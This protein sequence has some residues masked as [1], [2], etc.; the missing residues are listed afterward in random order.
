MNNL[1]D[2]RQYL[3]SLRQQ[4]EY[5]LERARKQL[6]QA[7][8]AREAAEK[9]E[10]YRKKLLQAEVEPALTTAETRRAWHRR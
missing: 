8:E 3:S 10:R 6:K 4:Y 1:R 5:S 7:R 9:L 2:T